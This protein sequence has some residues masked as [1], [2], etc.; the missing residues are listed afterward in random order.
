MSLNV[1]LSPLKLIRVVIADFGSVSDG[2]NISV[3]ER[4][5]L[6]Q[7]GVCDPTANTSI[8]M[9]GIYNR[10]NNDDSIF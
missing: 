1:L 10:L 7:A 3:K 9:E 5:N 8:D 6:I 4:V 2:A